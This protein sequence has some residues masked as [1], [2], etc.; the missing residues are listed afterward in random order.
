[1]DTDQDAF[2]RF[3]NVKLINIYTICWTMVH[4][5]I[6]IKFAGALARSSPCIVDIN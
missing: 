3:C 1:M 6:I 2:S 5:I 4:E